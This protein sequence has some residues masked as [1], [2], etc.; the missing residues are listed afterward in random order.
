MANLCPWCGKNLEKRYIDL[1]SSIRM[2]C[3]KCGFKIKDFP[4]PEKPKEEPK[5][6]AL[7][8][9]PREL[10]EATQTPSWHFVLGAIILI[11]VIA[12]IVKV[13]LV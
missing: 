5:S 7:E 9:L 12:V 10:P 13:F 3:G 4:K 8:V 11:L 6:D 2:A 1:G